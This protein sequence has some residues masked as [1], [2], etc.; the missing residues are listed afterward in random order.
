MLFYPVH[1]FDR[2][3]YELQE[4]ETGEYLPYMFVKGGTQTPLTIPHDGA[5]M[6]TPEGTAG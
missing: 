2:I 6:A 5:V 4:G 1:G 3:S